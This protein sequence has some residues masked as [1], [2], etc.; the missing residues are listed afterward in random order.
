MNTRRSLGFAAAAATTALVLTQPGTR[1]AAGATA[2]QAKVARGGLVAL[3][4]RDGP[5]VISRDF[6]VSTSTNWSGYAVTGGTY[7]YVHGSWTVPAVTCASGENSQSSTWVGLDGWGSDTVEQLG[8]T[9]GCIFGV[10]AYFP[11]TEMYPALPVP[12]DESMTPGDAMTGSVTSS[13]GGTSYLLV[14]TD[15]TKKWTYRTTAAASPADE[16]LSAEWITELPS[17]PVFCDNLTDF[18]SVTFRDA[19]A[20]GD[21][22]KG[23]ISS[24]AGYKAVDMENGTTLQAS[25]GP[26]SKNGESFTDRW[27]HA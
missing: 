3:G 20:V 14:L 8:S 18:G 16:D 21:G 9:T 13:A 4:L 17:C 26:L 2:V 6:A 22:K 25:V 5:A 7:T 19:T 11:W 15:N 27:H 24:F 10:A 23:S 1:P 12:L